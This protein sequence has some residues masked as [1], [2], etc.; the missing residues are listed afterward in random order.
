MF[1]YTDLNTCSKICYKANINGPAVIPVIWMSL[2]Y[3]Y[4]RIAIEKEYFCDPDYYILC[5]SNRND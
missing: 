1:S 2:F 3:S 5:S 4:Q